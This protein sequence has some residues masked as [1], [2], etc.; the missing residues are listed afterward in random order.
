MNGMKNYL[1][2]HGEGQFE[3]LVEIERDKVFNSVYLE[4]S[5]FSGLTLVLF[6]VK[7]R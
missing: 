3:E 5:L 4:F 2:K 6:S 7:S 1:L